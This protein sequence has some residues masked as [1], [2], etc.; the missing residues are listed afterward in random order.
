MYIYLKPID[1]VTKMYAALNVRLYTFETY[2]V[3]ITC[4]MKKPTLE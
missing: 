3:S 1:F 2:T 4:F